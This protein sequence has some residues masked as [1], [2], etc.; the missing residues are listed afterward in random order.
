[1]FSTSSFNE[2]ETLK[3]KK[4]LVS[5]HSFKV[6]KLLLISWYFS[7]SFL[8]W[9]I[10]LSKVFINVFKSFISYSMPQSSLT[11]FYNISSKD[12]ISPLIDFIF[13][14]I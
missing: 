13:W 2:K 12:L 6:V 11:T 3:T 4:L 10:D 8:F 7:F 1:M 9:S 5:K 14:L